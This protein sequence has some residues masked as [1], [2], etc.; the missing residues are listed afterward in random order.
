MY[1]SRKHRQQFTMRTAAEKPVNFEGQLSGLMWAFGNR[2]RMCASVPRVPSHGFGLFYLQTFAEI[3]CVKPKSLL[4]L[5]TTEVEKLNTR[6]S[7]QWWS[8]G[9]AI[10]QRVRNMCNDSIS[11]EWKR[12]KA[13]ASYRISYRLTGLLT[14]GLLLEPASLQLQL[15]LLQS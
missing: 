12:P 11:R 10:A 14:Q 15:I 6:K 8:I 7:G 2:Q 3:C 5:H 9:I 1:T 13:L 4:V